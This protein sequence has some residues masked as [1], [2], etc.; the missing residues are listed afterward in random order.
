MRRFHHSFRR[1][2]ALLIG[3]V[4]FLSGM[5]K[6]M[7]PVGTGL[8]VAEYFRFLHLDF[9]VPLG[10]ATGVAV[11]LLES[12]VGA[13]LLSGI[14]RKPTAVTVLCMVGFFTGLTLAL[15]LADPEMD[16]GCFGEAVR[17]T[18]FQS[19]LKNIILLVLALIAFIPLSDGF[20]ARNPKKWGFA[21]VAA[22]I[23]FFALSSWRGLPWMD[24]T[25]FA[26]GSQITSASGAA[27]DPATDRPAVLSFRDA[28]GEYGDALAADGEVLVLSVYAPERLDSLRWARM[29]ATVSD[30]FVCGIR[31]L[32]LAPS[33]DS[34][35]VTLGECL[36]FADPKTLL[37]LNRSN[38]GA[39]FL[40][41]GLIVTKWPASH[42]PKE[43][44]LTSLLRSEPVEVAT[45]VTTWGR[46]AYQGSLLLCIA[47]LI[48]L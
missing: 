6:L 2:C 12:L 10:K 18:H 42:L 44:D 23:I 15:Y 41:D 11:S 45:G 47:L 17:L 38:G 29:A 33:A 26:P 43:E 37:T 34:V 48:L 7:D 40:A 14:A 22:F 9:L 27:A 31:P 19:L 35:P 20:E 46:L 32:V 5:L 4:F 36:F 13:A 16:C 24:F 3:L 8:K 39:T 30:A 28:Y 1:F 25:P 21:L